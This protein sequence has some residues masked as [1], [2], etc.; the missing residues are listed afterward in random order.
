MKLAQRCRFPNNELFIT[1]LSLLIIFLLTEL[2]FRMYN[3]YKTLPQVD[4][5]SHMVVGMTLATGFYWMFSLTMIRRKAAAAIIFTLI[6]A[7]VWEILETLEEMVIPNAPYLID[8]FYWDG[9]SDIIVTVVSG[10]VILGIIKTV[11][12]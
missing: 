4:I 8:H 2:Y 12:K 11:R 9:F 1:A 7:I 10:M 5:I 3:L 6:A